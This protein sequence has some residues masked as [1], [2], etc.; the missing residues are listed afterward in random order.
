VRTHDPAVAAKL[1]LL[2][3]Q[4]A[5]ETEKWLKQTKKKGQQKILEAMEIQKDRRACHRCTHAVLRAC[6]T[7]SAA[8]AA[9]Q[10]TLAGQEGRGGEGEASA[11]GAGGRDGRSIPS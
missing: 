11:R 9:A 10:G 7:D 8:A 1:C 2:L 6:P 5:K 4:T 3:T